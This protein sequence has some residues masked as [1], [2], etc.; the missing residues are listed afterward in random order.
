MVLNGIEIPGMKCGS[1]KRVNVREKAAKQCGQNTVSDEACILNKDSSEQSAGCTAIESRDTQRRVKMTEATKMRHTSELCCSGR[2]LSGTRACLYIGRDY[3][4]KQSVTGGVSVNH[5]DG[6]KSSVRDTLE[7]VTSRAIETIDVVVMTEPPDYPL[8][9]YERSASENVEPL[10][11][12]VG[13]PVKRTFRLR[14]Y[15]EPYREW[16]LH[17][18]NEQI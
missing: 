5:I 15:R 17:R 9:L 3:E 10:G 18:S 4:R 7:V 13:D 8:L 16:Q 2:P 12:P 1:A 11:Q 14:C 6:V